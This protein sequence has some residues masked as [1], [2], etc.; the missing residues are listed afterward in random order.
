[1]YIVSRVF[2]RGIE[3]HFSDQ[4]N[5]NQIFSSSPNRHKSQLGT[6]Q[7]RLCTTD[8]FLSSLPES[9]TL[10]ISIS[11]TCECGAVFLLPGCVSPIWGCEPN[12][13]PRT[14]RQFPGLEI[15]VLCLPEMPLIS[16]S[17]VRV[18][19]ASAPASVTLSPPTP[20]LDSNPQAPMTANTPRFLYPAYPS[21]PL[22]LSLSLF[23]DEHPLPQAAHPSFPRP[24]ELLYLPLRCLLSRVWSYTLRLLSSLLLHTGPFLLATALSNPHTLSR[25]FWFWLCYSPGTM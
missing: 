2:L 16:F 7:P 17:P 4:E 3:E 21:S 18:R 15:G 8:I 24:P 5:A 6:G 1:M 12:L 13:G 10:H 14:R 23:T 20:S 25:F 22:S 9:L 19:C 11:Y